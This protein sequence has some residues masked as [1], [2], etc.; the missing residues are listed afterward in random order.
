MLYLGFDLVSSQTP[1]CRGKGHGG[2]LQRRAAGAASTVESSS[3]ERKAQ[4]KQGCEASEGA[5]AQ[6]FALLCRCGLSHSSEHGLI[7][8]Q[9]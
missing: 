2:L 3:H 8:F 9:G 4:Q 1:H 6:Q 7:P 5:G